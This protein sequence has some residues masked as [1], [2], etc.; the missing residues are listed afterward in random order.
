MYSKVVQQLKK[1]EKE[2]KEVKDAT[3]ESDDIENNDIS[4]TLLEQQRSELSENENKVLS[5]FGTGKYSFRSLS[6]IKNE[7]SLPKEK[8]QESLNI[9]VSKNL[10]IQTYGKNNQNLWYL[11]TSGKRLVGLAKK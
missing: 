9:L 5:A 7:T 4:K 6:G 1:T 11:T 8:V 10:L 3:S 2:A